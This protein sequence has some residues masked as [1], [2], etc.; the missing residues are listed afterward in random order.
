MMGWFRQHPISICVVLLIIS[1]TL[2]LVFN[3]SD[4]GFALPLRSKKLLALCVVGIAV[5]ISTLIFQTVT[6]NPILTPALLGYDALYVL[7]KSLMVFFLGAAGLSTLS[8]LFKFSLEVVI[9]LGLSLLLFRLLFTKQNQ[10]LTRLILVGVIFGVLFRS[11]S[12]LV[13]RL[14]SPDEFITVQSVSYAQFNTINTQL[15]MISTVMC[16]A[17]VV[18]VWRVRFACDILMLGRAFAI[19]LG[20]DYQ[21]LTLYLLVIIAILV[22]VSTALV[23]PITFFG[24]L[25]CALT[26]QLTS[27]MHHTKRLILVSLV[28]MLCLV[29]GQMLF[30]HILKMAGVLS[31]AIELIGGLV[32]LWL[33]LR[34][35]RHDNS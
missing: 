28:S 34:E 32:F 20:I 26:N 23:G 10:D 22:S 25:V 19:N 16:M 31:V 8:P 21:K 6:N 1:S 12:A 30:E 18:A 33:V 14:I 17:C 35:F 9:M 2:F 15:L 3:V 27:S 24:L 11:L 5:G 7:I 13:A 4:F 29:G